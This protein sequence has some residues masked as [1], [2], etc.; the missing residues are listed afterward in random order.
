MMSMFECTQD[1]SLPLKITGLH[2]QCLSRKGCYA[3]YALTQQSYSTYH[4]GNN[5]YIS[6]VFSMVTCESALQVDIAHCKVQSDKTVSCR[7]QCIRSC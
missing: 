6:N 2:I 4:M 7:L 1:R 3:G 5:G